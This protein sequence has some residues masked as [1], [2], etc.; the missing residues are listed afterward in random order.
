MENLTKWFKDFSD[1]VTKYGG[2]FNAHCHLD[3]AH[4]LNKEYLEH[5]G[6][7]PIYA[8]SAPLK[9]KQNLVGDLHKGIAYYKE[10]LKCRMKRAIQQM[11]ELNTSKVI[12]FIDTTADNVKLSALE[13]ALELKE[14]FKN[15]IELQIAAYPIFGFKESDKERL[16]IFEE[17]VKL[18]DIVGGLPERDEMPGHVGYDEHL[19]ILFEI[20]QKYNKPLHIHVDQA[21]DPEEKGTETLIEAARFLL[22]KNYYTQEEPFVWAIHSISPAAYEEERFIKVIDG[23]LKYNI[24]VICCPT[25]AISMRQNRHKKAPIHNSIARVLEMLEA[26]VKVRI[27][28][29]NIADIFVPSGTPDVG[30]EMWLLSNVLR[31][32]S[33]DILAK[34][35]TATPLNEMDREIVRNYIKQD[36]ITK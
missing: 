20:A 8:S 22:D 17:A 33:P 6:L 1:Q 9:V 13:V 19:K 34:I 14:E 21:N 2:Y 31:F 4:T 24:G 26:G 12:S 7:D 28:T 10:N 11:Q 25:A 32:Y 3:R 18:S 36:N 27:G 35:A 30:M 29:D 5:K 23:L 15:K 16:S